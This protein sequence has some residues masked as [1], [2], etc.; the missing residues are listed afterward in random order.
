MLSRSSVQHAGKPWRYR[1][2]SMECV[3]SHRQTWMMIASLAASQTGG[4]PRT[5]RA[6]GCQGVCERR[7]LPLSWPPVSLEAHSRR[8]RR[9]D[10]NCCERFDTHRAGS[11]EW[12][13]IRAAHRCPQ[14][15]EALVSS[16]CDPAFSRPCANDRRDAW[17]SDTNCQSRRPVQTLGKLR[18]TGTHPPKLAFGHGTN[19]IS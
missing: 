19:A 8:N 7:D 11:A 14:R 5:W 12:V 15:A 17:H 16:P 4:V 18:R 6:A 1:L 2:G 10:P 13:C 9:C 3:S